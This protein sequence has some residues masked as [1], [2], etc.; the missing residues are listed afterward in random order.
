MRGRIESPNKSN[1]YLWVRRRRPQAAGNSK[2]QRAQGRDQ[3]P[4]AQAD[5]IS[6]IQGQE[7]RLACGTSLGLAGRQRRGPPNHTVYYCEHLDEDKMTDWACWGLPDNATCLRIASLTCRTV[8]P[9]MRPPSSRTGTIPSRQ[10][11]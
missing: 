4:A 3:Q 11:Q 10:L 2:A 6:I 1:A 5:G 7:P 8:V 9:I